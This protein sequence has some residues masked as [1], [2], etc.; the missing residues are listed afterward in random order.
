MHIRSNQTGAQFDILLKLVRGEVDD[1]AEE[2]DN[3]KSKEKEK[4]SGDTRKKL[5]RTIIRIAKLLGKNSATYRSDLQGSDWFELLTKYFKD[6][7]TRIKKGDE[8]KGKLIESMKT[9]HIPLHLLTSPSFLRQLY[10][11]FHYGIAERAKQSTDKIISISA[12]PIEEEVCHRIQSVFT[13][14]QEL[15]NAIDKEPTALA[16]TIKNYTKDLAILI[17]ELTMFRKKEDASLSDR[18]KIIIDAYIEMQKRVSNE[19]LTVLVEQDKLTPEIS[20]DFGDSSIYSFELFMRSKL[21]RILGLG[22]SDNIFDLGLSQ[23]GENLDAKKAAETLRSFNID[24]DLIAKYIYSPIEGDQETTHNPL[25]ESGKL[26]AAKPNELYNLAKQLISGIENTAQYQQKAMTQD[27]QTM[28]DALIEYRRFLE[29]EV[30]AYNL[31]DDSH[32]GSFGLASP[33]LTQLAILQKSK[34]NKD[35]QIALLREVEIK[36]GAETELDKIRAQLNALQAQKNSIEDKIAYIEKTI[37]PHTAFAMQAASGRLSRLAKPRVDAEVG[38]ALYGFS[39]AGINQLAQY[40]EKSTEERIAET[41]MGPEQMRSGSA[42]WVD[43]QNLALKVALSKTEEKSSIEIA[44][45]YNEICAETIY[46]K[47]EISSPDYSQGTI[48]R[49]RNDFANRLTKMQATVFPKKSKRINDPDYYNTTAIRLMSQQAAQHPGSGIPYSKF[50]LPINMQ[51]MH[52]VKHE[53]NTTYVAMWEFLSFEDTIVAN[54]KRN[55]LELISKIKTANSAMEYI[56]IV[57]ALTTLTSSIS[58]SLSYFLK[59]QYRAIIEEAVRDI[60]DKH[61]CDDSVNILQAKRDELRALKYTLQSAC[62]QDS[63]DIRKLL[64]V[65]DQKINASYQTTYDLANLHMQDEDRVTDIVITKNSSQSDKNLDRFHQTF[66]TYIDNAIVSATG[67]ASEQDYKQGKAQKLLSILG[68]PSEWNHFLW[69]V[70]TPAIRDT[71]SD[72]IANYMKH[73]AENFAVFCA[74]RIMAALYSEEGQLAYV[75]CKTES[76]KLSFMLKTIVKGTASLALS[77]KYFDN[78]RSFIDLVS[79]TD[80]VYCG[81]DHARRAYTYASPSM[82]EKKTRYRHH[83]FFGKGTGNVEIAYE[84]YKELVKSVGM[85]K[86]R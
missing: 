46:G 11:S 58:D 13:Q 67:V 44:V 4:D 17:S 76:Q 73:E 50:V 80:F 82:D 48:E 35:R 51:I 49:R 29:D 10:Q 25:L 83:C 34:E 69:N 36:T 78:R 53:L 74:K 37:E 63:E 77:N 57:K 61:F 14:L 68:N 6:L 33:Y 24:E 16:A 31:I 39:N 22:I 32:S 42:A 62:Y 27:Q 7:S 75:A 3:T 40:E 38:N 84:D 59:R 5:K 26:P 52:T 56:A 81:D 12:N 70:L 30:C 65:I 45:K 86:V 85:T 19:I 28:Y 20:S 54:T 15:F 1:K 21:R 79:S 47:N 23:E 60:V 64:V 71:Y 8:I 55:I 66:A 72:E 9:K 43:K 2:V 41:V 18:N